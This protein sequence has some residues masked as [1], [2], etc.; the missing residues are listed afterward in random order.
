[1]LNIEKKYQFRIK[2]DRGIPLINPSIGKHPL[3]GGFHMFNIF[4][5]ILLLNWHRHGKHNY[6]DIFFVFYLKLWCSFLQFLNR[7]FCT[8]LALFKR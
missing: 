2:C 8:F 4:F 3:L 5:I 6:N 1:M 7:N